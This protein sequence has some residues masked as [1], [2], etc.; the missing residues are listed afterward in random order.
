MLNLMKVTGPMSIR[1]IGLDHDITLMTGI[2]IIPVEN[3][4]AK[5]LLF[6]SRDDNDVK[7]LNAE[8]LTNNLADYQLIETHGGHF[9]WVGEDMEKIKKKR[10]EFLNTINFN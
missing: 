5:S 2:E 3:I 8:Y 1:K 6:Y 10:I 9:M 7:W 4:S